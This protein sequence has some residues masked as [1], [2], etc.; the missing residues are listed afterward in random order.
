MIYQAK[1]DKEDKSEETPLE[2]QLPSSTNVI[3]NTT[4]ANSSSS[5]STES[6]PTDFL[7]LIA[8]T[9]S[10]SSS[11]SEE[12][13]PDSHEAMHNRELKPK[14]TVSSAGGRDKRSYQFLVGLV[15][16][17]SRFEMTRARKSDGDDMDGIEKDLQDVGRSYAD[18]DDK[19]DMRAAGDL[20][21]MLVKISS[22]PKEW[23][24]V[25]EMLVEIDNDLQKSK[26]I[27]DEIDKTPSNSTAPKNNI[28]ANEKKSHT[29]E[30][31]EYINSKQK[32]HD[33]IHADAEQR[34]TDMKKWPPFDETFASNQPQRQTE[35]NLELIPHSQ[36][37]NN[38]GADPTKVSYPHN[39]AYH[40]VTGKPL[41]HHT[42]SNSKGPKA[43][44]AVSVIA[45]KNPIE[46]DEMNLENELRQ[47]KPWT[48]QQNLR[49]M[50][51]IRS[52]WVIQ[53][54]KER[55][56]DGRED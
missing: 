43:Y 4:I 22:H 23:K 38:N 19:I 35:H 42:N 11:S 29:P 5:T 54:S 7:A 8:N 21:E 3:S 30:H 47:L 15:K 16:N 37:V 56:Y 55:E 53:S 14:L 41:Y 17:Q 33:Y 44:I 46:R 2:K 12:G 1:A 45:P 34:Q 50:A 10:S 48:H 52:K 36:N 40:R 32:V 25:H 49:N 31:R 27:L 9:T 6:T 39:F 28:S 24:S 20:M 13:P 18:S 26:R 51:D